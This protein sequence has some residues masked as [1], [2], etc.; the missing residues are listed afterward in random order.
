MW[1]HMGFSSRYTKTKPHEL[2]PAVR[3]AVEAK[4]GSEMSDIDGAGNGKK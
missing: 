4:R 2:L 3:E 1:C